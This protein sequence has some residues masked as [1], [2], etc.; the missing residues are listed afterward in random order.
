[1]LPQ[2]LRG[3]IGSASSTR[4]RPVRW[5]VYG[6]QAVRHVHLGCGP[7]TGPIAQRRWSEAW[8]LCE[9]D[10]YHPRIAHV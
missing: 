8:I 7:G 3:R 2:F 4:V 5:S 6:V 10:W 9:Y 1:M